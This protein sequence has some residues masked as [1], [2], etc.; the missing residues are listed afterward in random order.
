MY[1]TLLLKFKRLR[2]DILKKYI[3]KSCI[4]EAK[5]IYESSSKLKWPI[6]FII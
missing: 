3:N 6:D 4:I 1:S 5:T 2:L